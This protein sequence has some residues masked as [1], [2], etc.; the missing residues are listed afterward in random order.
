MYVSGTDHLVC[1]HLRTLLY[2]EPL[3]NAFALDSHF[4]KLVPVGIGIRDEFGPFFQSLEPMI[5]NLSPK[6]IA[7]SEPETRYRKYAIGKKAEHLKI[8]SKVI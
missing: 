1:V 4:C 3:T 7:S 8:V 5:F 6:N 2:G